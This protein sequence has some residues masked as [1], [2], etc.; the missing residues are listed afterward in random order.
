MLRRQQEA[1][2]AVQERM[3]LSEDGR[4]PTGGIG[5]DG[6]GRNGG[7]RGGR[8]EEGGTKGLG[9]GKPDGEGAMLTRGEGR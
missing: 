4:R 9:E 2:T 5:V 1:T 7:R 3:P 6:G 8:R